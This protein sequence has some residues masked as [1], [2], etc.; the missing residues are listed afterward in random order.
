MRP[1]EDTAQR[2]STTCGS[3]K[4]DIGEVEGEFMSGNA[5]PEYRLGELGESHSDAIRRQ[6]RTEEMRC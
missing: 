1:S 2:S 3:E 5:G 4:K 6:R